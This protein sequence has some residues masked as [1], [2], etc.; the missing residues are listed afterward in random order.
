MLQEDR[1]M[2]L[3]DDIELIETLEISKE[4]EDEIKITIDVNKAT[5]KKNQI[6]R[7]NYRYVGFVVS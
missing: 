2:P 4:K 6:S 7:E 5:M 3:V 1:G